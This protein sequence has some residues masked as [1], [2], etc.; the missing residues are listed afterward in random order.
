[1]IISIENRL[2][3]PER[4]SKSLTSG[5][6]KKKWCVNLAEKVAGKGH[7]DGNSLGK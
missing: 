3:V 7:K 4:V 6:S 1:L 2:P 5:Y